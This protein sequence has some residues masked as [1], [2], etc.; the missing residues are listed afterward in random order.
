MIDQIALTNMEKTT[1][2]RRHIIFN[3]KVYRAPLDSQERE[4]TSLRSNFQLI[5]STTSI[6]TLSK[7]KVSKRKGTIV[8]EAT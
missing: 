1:T 5:T 3:F 6:P 4:R 7:A 2:T 8:R